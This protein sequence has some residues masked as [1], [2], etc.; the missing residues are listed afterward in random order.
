MDPLTNRRIN[1]A[2]RAL[3]DLL[4]SETAYRFMAGCAEYMSGDGLAQLKRAA[5]NGQRWAFRL[6]IDAMKV[7]ARMEMAKA[8]AAGRKVGPK[9]QVTTGFARDGD[10]T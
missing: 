10:K 1:E 2:Q 8:M 3:N 6:L 9:V 4:D 5:Q 7:L